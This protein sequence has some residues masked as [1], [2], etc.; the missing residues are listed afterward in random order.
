MEPI[1]VTGAG[2][3]SAIGVGKEETLRSLRSGT[4]GIH[5]MKFLPSCHRDLLVGEIRLSNEEM[6]VM[7][8]Q[9]G[10]RHT[11]IKEDQFGKQRFTK[12]W[13]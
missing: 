6:K 1:F 7:L 12:S 13:L 2:V 3:V 10:F 5:E 11:E 8:Q 4:T 9:E